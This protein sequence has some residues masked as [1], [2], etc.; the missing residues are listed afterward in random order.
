M[1]TGIEAHSWPHPHRQRD[2]M[3]GIYIPD[4]LSWLAT[5]LGDATA[6]SKQIPAGCPRTA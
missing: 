5:L 1:S 4:V 3:D 2:E 6:A